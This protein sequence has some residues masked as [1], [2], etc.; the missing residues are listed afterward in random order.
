[1]QKALT[2]SPSKTLSAAAMALAT[3]ATAACQV[4]RDPPIFDNIFKKLARCMFLNK[5]DCTQGSQVTP[6][7]S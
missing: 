6:C 5:Q 2:Q 4:P 3:A 1:M 7:S